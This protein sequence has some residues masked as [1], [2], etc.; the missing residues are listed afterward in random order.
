M[1]AKTAKAVA[2]LVSTPRSVVGEPRRL[3]VVIAA[4][5]PRLQS[6]DEDRMAREHSAMLVASTMPN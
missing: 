1:M 6:G 2:S 3:A 5:E 4:I